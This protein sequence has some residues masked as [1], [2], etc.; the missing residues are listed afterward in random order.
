MSAVGETTRR[1]SMTLRT[2]IA[3]LAAVAVGA[4]IAITAAAVFFIVRAELYAQFD[5]DLVSR[6]QAVGQAVAD[7]DQVTRIPAELLDNARVG[8]LTSDNVMYPARGGTPPPS[9]AA[10][11]DVAQGGLASSVRGVVV[12]GESLRVAAVPVGSGN[13]LVLAQPTDSVDQTLGD[14]GLIL[15]LIGFLGVLGAAAAGYTVA[16]TGL[17]PVAELTAAAERVARTEELTPIDVTSDDEIG[18]LAESFN[19]MLISLDAGRER[20]RRLVADAGHELRTPL[21]SIRTNLDLLSQADSEGV[22]LPPSERAALLADVRE[23]IEELGHLIGDLVQLS[24]GTPT[25]ETDDIVELSAIVERS[26]ER[27]QR[28]APGIVFDVDMQ[29]WWMAGE[30]ASLERAT[31]NLLDN[32]AKWSPP[33]GTIRVRL[34]AGRLTVADDGPGIPEHD[35]PRVFERFYRSSSARG[36]P[37]SG[38]GLAIVAQAAQQHGGSVEVS[39]APSGGALM[40]LTLPGSP[41]SLDQGR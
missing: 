24:R 13:A 4:A 32:A 7:P 22:D 23:Q 25:P 10:E 33:R 8:L 18:R 15:V 28:R 27:V 38:L 14:L 20:E 9:S 26:V 36:L 39:A 19:A 1:R 41:E 6:T 40:T 30:A 2:R 31:T 35:R 34:A 37:G 17:R 16:R 21:T 12:D 11:L 29:P 3:L 5:A